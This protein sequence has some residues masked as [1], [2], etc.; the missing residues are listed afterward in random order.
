MDIGS[1]ATGRDTL[2]EAETMKVSWNRWVRKTHYW[3][4]LLVAVPLIVVIG[5][6]ILLLLKKEIAWIQPSTM[7][8]SGRIPIIE[9]ERVFEAVAAVDAA[10]ITRWED[11]ERLDV[12]PSKGVVKVRS[13]SH[14]EVQVDFV[15]GVVLQTA[16]RRSDLIESIHDGTFFHDAAKLWIF[17]PS[18]V[19]LLVMWLTGLYLFTVPRM[20]T[21]RRELKMMRG[22]K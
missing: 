21:R 3:A 20:A 8:G 22:R 7:N 12:R 15:T 11:I 13:H 1:A 2:R 6:G 10:G 5:S 18:A 9:F 4:S 19:V 14:W 17:L 16:Y